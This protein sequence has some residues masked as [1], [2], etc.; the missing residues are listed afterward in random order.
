MRSA[1]SLVPTKDFTVRFC[2]RALKKSCRVRDE[3]WLTAPFETTEGTQVPRERGTPQ[4]GVVTPRTQKITSN[5]SGGWNFGGNRVRID[6]CRNGL[7]IYDKWRA[8]A[9]PKRPNA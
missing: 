3:R 7:Y 5:L 2:L 9:S 8:Q 1:F 6:A 4:G